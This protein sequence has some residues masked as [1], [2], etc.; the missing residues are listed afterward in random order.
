MND[1]MKLCGRCRHEH[2]YGILRYSA[3]NVKLYGARQC[4]TCDCEDFAEAVEGVGDSSVPMITPSPAELKA[5]WRETSFLSAQVPMATRIA[6]RQ[7]LSLEDGAEQ[8]KEF[9][10]LMISQLTD[11]RG[12]MTRDG[13]KFANL[14]SHTDEV[15]ESM[16]GVVQLSERLTGLN[17]RIDNTNDRIDRLATMMSAMMEKFGVEAKAP[18][19]P[20]PE[21]VAD[22]SE[23]ARSVFTQANSRLRDEAVAVDGKPVNDG[24]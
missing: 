3:D 1:V 11:I 21:S 23:A 14:V 5:L 24:D 22:L 6:I 7:I 9:M 10:G 2:S 17:Q 20:D 8:R 16:K 12:E 13:S 4:S 18:E 19:H 15:V